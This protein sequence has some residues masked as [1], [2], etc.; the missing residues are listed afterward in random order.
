MYVDKTS[1]HK[2]ISMKYYFK[3]KGGGVIRERQR[4]IEK[5]FI[6][7]IKILSANLEVIGPFL[8]DAWS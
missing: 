1:V 3:A 5:S 8:A 4:I 7:K 2:Q 6:L